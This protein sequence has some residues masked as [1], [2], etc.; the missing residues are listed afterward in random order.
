MVVIDPPFVTRNVW[1]EYT[2]TAKALLRYSPC[3]DDNESIICPGFVFATTLAEN[4]EFMYELF[5]AKATVFK[6]KVTNLV[7]QYKVYINCIDDCC[8]LQKK[9]PEIIED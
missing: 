7:Y 3:T 5:H 9:N 4:H 6:P 1:E 8:L 2:T